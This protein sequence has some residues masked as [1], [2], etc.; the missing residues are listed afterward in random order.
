MNDLPSSSFNLPD[1][2]GTEEALRFGE[3]MTRDQYILLSGAKAAL[4]RQ[5][6]NEQDLQRKLF[7]AV[8][9]QLYR[10][11]LEV[12]PEIVLASTIGGQRSEDVKAGAAHV[13]GER[14]W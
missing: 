5:F 3:T 7:I 9:I 2:K 6:A 11:A 13:P 4:H 12:A 10:E 8:Q 1:F 14:P